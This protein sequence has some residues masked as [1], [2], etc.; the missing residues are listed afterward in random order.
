MAWAR[1]RF[2]LFDF[3]ALGYNVQERTSNVRGGEYLVRV[4]AEMR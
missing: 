4:P 2:R 3:A 1:S